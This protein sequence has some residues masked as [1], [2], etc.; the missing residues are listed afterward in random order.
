MKRRKEKMKKN[1]VY[2]TKDL[3]EG[4]FL[5]ANRLR[6]LELQQEGKFYYFV[7]EDK[8]KAKSLSDK[9]WQREGKVIPKDYAESIRSL[10]DR[11]YARK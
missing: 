11:L 9:Y 6:L 3:Y 2:L 4:A 10:K 5:Y 8:E 7:F 1:N